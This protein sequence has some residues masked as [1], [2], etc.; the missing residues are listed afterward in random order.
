MEN[1][2]A[3]RT[4]TANVANQRLVLHVRL[5]CGSLSI[6]ITTQYQFW[7]MSSLFRGYCTGKRAWQ[8]S[9]KFCVIDE[10]MNGCNNLKIH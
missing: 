2:T 6:T 5:R 3:A 8:M 7:Q 4:R 1:R 9:I 10:A